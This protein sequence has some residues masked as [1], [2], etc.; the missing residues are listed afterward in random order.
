MRANTVPVTDP[1]TPSIIIAKHLM[2]VTSQ[3]MV[4][5]C[6]PRMVSVRHG[7]LS[8]QKARSWSKGGKIKARA[9]L[10]TAPM[11]VIRPSRSG[12]PNA[13]PARGGGGDKCDLMEL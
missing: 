10:A 5:Y 2:T 4:R 13:S 7:G 12:I 1:N 6:V 3:G 11:R 9:A 8:L